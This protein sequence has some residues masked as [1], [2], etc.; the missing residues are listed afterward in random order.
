MNSASY[1]MIQLFEKVFNSYTKNI[2]QL[3]GTW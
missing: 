3:K 1:K 2:D